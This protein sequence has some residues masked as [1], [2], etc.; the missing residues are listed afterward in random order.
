MESHLE[1]IEKTN[2][3]EERSNLDILSEDFEFALE[4]ELKAPK[5]GNRFV[6]KNGERL[7]EDRSVIEFE[8]SDKFSIPEEAKYSI[9]LGRNKVTASIADFD[10]KERKI[11]IK[12]EE[13]F[14][15]DIVSCAI[16]F[17]NEYILKK[18]LQDIQSDYIKQST[19]I[20]D[21]INK[22]PSIKEHYDD[23]FSIDFNNKQIDFINMALR[24]N[25]SYLWGPPGTGK[26]Y[27]LAKIIKLFNKD[28]KRVLI[29]SN[30]NL[31]VDSLLNSVV[32]N[33]EE[34]EEN[35]VLR[36]GNISENFKESLAQYH[37]DNTVLRINKHISNRIIELEQRRGEINKEID[38]IESS[39][40]SLNAGKVARQIESIRKK[41]EQFNE[42][43][44][45]Q[46]TLLG[47][48]RI[49]LASVE[50]QIL[51]NENSLTGWLL[52]GDLKRNLYEKKSEFSTILDKTKVKIQEQEKNKPDFAALISN[53]LKEIEYNK[54][55]D[56]FFDDIEKEEEELY[57]L[58]NEREELKEELEELNK[59][60]SDAEIKVL[61]GSKIVATT[62]AK[63]LFYNRTDINKFDVVILDEVSMILAPMLFLNT[64]LS[65]D[66]VIYSGDF[67]QLGSI[68]STKTPRAV[69]ILKKD[70][71]DYGKITT[72]I[73][74]NSYHNVCTMLSEQFRAPD[75]ICSIYSNIFYNGELKTDPSRISNELDLPHPFTKNL[76]LIDTSK[77]NSKI[78]GD[79]KSNFGHAFLTTKLVKNYFSNM[80]IGIISPYNDQT[81]ITKDIL[82][83]LKLEDIKCDTVHKYQGNE[84]DIIIYDLPVTYGIKNGFQNFVGAKELSDTG[85]RNINV[86]L[87]RA[88][89][90][91]IMVVNLN[92]I[93]NTKS[94]DKNDLLVKTIEEVVDSAQVI[95]AEDLV[96]LKSLYSTSARKEINFNEEALL[97]LDETD[98]EST[99]LTDIK[100]AKS[101]IMIYSPFIT[102]DKIKQI[103]STLL[104]AT[105]NDVNIKLIM[106]PLRRM[107]N[108][109]DA[110]EIQKFFIKTLIPQSKNKI[111][112]E[113]KDDFHHKTIFIDNNIYYCGSMNFLSYSYA[114]KIEERMKRYVSE[115]MSLNEAKRE[116]FEKFDQA[117]SVF[118]IFEKNTCPAC[119]I[120]K[121]KTYLVSK[122]TKTQPTSYQCFN[123]KCGN[124][125]ENKE[126]YHEL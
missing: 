87:S 51:K 53:A 106:R 125:D 126:V 88:K 34:L 98:F 75:N 6:L 38:E 82:K 11:L 80:D 77:L 66:K 54:S 14:N 64:L 8:V 47:K 70:I 30:S 39:Y 40:F 79:S 20:E 4:Q 33:D 18:M 17:T 67:R 71:F 57:E 69:N 119:S 28:N 109:N 117:R 89:E 49:E 50:R 101:H 107:K 113:F 35:K 12:F 78:F 25:I 83:N 81:G 32:K 84:K 1:E 52:K 2:V 43:I 29:L 46:N 121:G 86:A 90:C 96:D 3:K 104:E 116:S 23:F 21:I 24:Q 61:N 74:E 105:S 45:K 111:T 19:L 7:K 36:T 42:Y 62:C 58:T 9:Y 122:Y 22:K 120:C 108:R 13:A 85:A 63:A 59:E 48:T 72:S 73:E 76:I 118:E 94:L 92:F 112:L 5:K 56:D 114:S 95:N 102:H 115:T 10:E 65:T 91:L 97:S 93:R 103:S 99:L 100:N 123:D 16:E 31:A 44:K 41:E 15:K 60:L 110:I 27:T 68:F 124:I 55:C 37:I 26:S